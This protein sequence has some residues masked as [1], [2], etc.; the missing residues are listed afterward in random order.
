[1]VSFIQMMQ[2]CLPIST[3]Y[4][5]HSHSVDAELWVEA[6]NVKTGSHR[7]DV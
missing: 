4:G 7:L 6:S 5:N 1:M 2:K 3:H